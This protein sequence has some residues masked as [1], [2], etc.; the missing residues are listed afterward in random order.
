[1]S[2][3]G[4][5]TAERGPTHTRASPGAQ[6]QPLVVALALAEPRVQ[7]R[8]DVAEPRLEPP[9]GLRRQARSRG[10][11]RSRRGRPRASPATARR[12]TSV[13]PEPVTPWS[14]NRRASARLTQ[15]W[16]DGVERARCSP[17]SAGGAVEPPADRHRC[18]AARRALRA[19]ASRARAPRAGAASGFRAWPRP[20][21]RRARAPRARLRWRS[22]RRASPS[23]A[24][25]AG[26]GQ[27]GDQHALAPRPA[28]GPGR[29]HQRE[30]PRRR[31]A[32]LA[33]R[34][35]P[36]ARPGRA[37]TPGGRTA[38]GSAS[39]SGASSD[40]AASSITTP[41]V[42]RRAERDPQQRADADV[43]LVGAQPVVERPTD[44]A[45][46]RQRLDPGDQCGLANWACIDRPEGKVRRG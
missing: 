43:G 41:S 19:R 13:L 6:P 24:S 26:V 17:V 32:V 30:R 21:V 31:R 33:R 22:V 7:H 4:A 2:A 34:S 9:D 8:D 3:S 20:P 39:R 12:Y 37:G 28:R 42:V 44:G 46:E 38:S 15:R 40:S 45:R 1:M 16:Q 18:R 25:R 29:E 27:L 35:T 23:S 11:A 14:R 5:N 36:P 10:R